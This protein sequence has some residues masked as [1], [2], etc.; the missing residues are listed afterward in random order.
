MS[1]QDASCD[2]DRLLCRLLVGNDRDSKECDRRDS[3]AQTS[4]LKIPTVTKRAK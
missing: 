2:K 3:Y 4:V 1:F